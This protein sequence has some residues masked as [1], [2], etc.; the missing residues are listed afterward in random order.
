MPS[1]PTISLDDLEAA[2]AECQRIEDRWENYSGNN[3]N[4]FVAQRDA[5]RSRVA[6]MTRL[7]KAQGDLPMT[8]HEAL[9]AELGRVAPNARH[10]D[11][12][13]HNGATYQRLFSPARTSLSGKTVTEW[14]RTWKKI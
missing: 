3:P 2:K 9:C 7:L 4:K 14:D 10:N 13:E 12:V 8:E 11:E 1:E 6:S 5:A